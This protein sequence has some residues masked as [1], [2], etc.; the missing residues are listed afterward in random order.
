MHKIRLEKHIPARKYNSEAPRELDRIVDKCLSKSPEKRWR[1]AQALVMALDNFVAKHIEINY[2]A[3]IVLFLQTQHVVTADEAEQ[4]INP[5]LAGP[6]AGVRAQSA[7]AAR[8]MIA[9]S[10]SVQ[11]GIGLL[12]AL[13]ITLIHLIPVGA[14]RPNIAPVPVYGFVRIMVHPWGVIR[15]EN[16]RLTTTPDVNPLRLQ[17]GNHKLTIEHDSFLPF[18]LDVRVPR[19]TREHPVVLLVDLETEGTRKASKTTN[20]EAE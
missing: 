10:A 8:Q 12:T 13:M 11:L 19:N 14:G 3:R 18:S 7:Y 20:P 2:N 15:D 17:T 9:R 5:A 6:G 4:Y 16:K 1:S